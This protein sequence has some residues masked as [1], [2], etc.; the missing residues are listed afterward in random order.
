MKL[1]INDETFESAP[2]KFE[3]TDEKKETL[4][5]QSNINLKVKFFW[6]SHGNLVEFTNDKDK[7]TFSKKDCTI[8][9]EKENCKIDGVEIETWNLIVNGEKMNGS[10]YRYNYN[11][12][13]KN[14]NIKLVLGWG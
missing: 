4:F 9:I 10:V 2:I 11:P 3:I 6:D 12:N 5:K 14:I 7:K 1:T 13:T 8:E